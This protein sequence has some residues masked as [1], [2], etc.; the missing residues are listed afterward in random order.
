MS[1][2]TNHCHYCF[3]PG[4][5]DGEDFLC[6]HRDDCSEVTGVYE[7][8]EENFPGGAK[9]AGCDENFED[10]DHYVV[11]PTNKVICLGCLVQGVEV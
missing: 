6:N 1:L 4:E 10:G 11:S 3:I 7:Y 2:R 5:W 8:L 9:C